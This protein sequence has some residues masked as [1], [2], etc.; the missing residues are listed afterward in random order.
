MSRIREVVIQDEAEDHFVVKKGVEV[1]DKIVLD[2][3][4]QVRDGEKVEYRVVI[5]EDAWKSESNLGGRVHR[6]AK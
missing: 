4:R 2:G 6:P 3:V 1:G 5:R